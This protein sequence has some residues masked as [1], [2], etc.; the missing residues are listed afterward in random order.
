MYWTALE[1]PPYS[2]DLS[3]CHCH[4]FGPLKE[5]LG[6]QHF[7]DDEQ[8]ENYLC[9]WLQTHPPFYNAGIKKTPNPLAKMQRERWELC[10][11]V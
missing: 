9:K 6:G 8:V 1:H 11:K 7:N 2:Q 10:R 5:A 3:L 4:L